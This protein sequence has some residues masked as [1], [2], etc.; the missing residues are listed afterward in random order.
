[1]EAFLA[2]LATFYPTL[3]CL[4]VVLTLKTVDKD[5]L[6]GLAAIIGEHHPRQVVNFFIRMTYYFTG[7]KSTYL[8]SCP[9]WPASYT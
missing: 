4:L 5:L 7:A 8:A 3:T 9:L 1:M 2:Q 6:Q